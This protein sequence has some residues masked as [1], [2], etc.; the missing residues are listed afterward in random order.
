M[1]IQESRGSI[2][3]VWSDE[4]LLVIDKP[5]G[6]LTHSNSFDRTSPTVVM[7]LGSRLG[8]S[9]YNV[10]RLDRMTTGAMVVARTH[11][12]ARELSEQFRNRNVTKHYLAVVR[13][14]LDDA[15]S[16]T[17]PI[18]H[19]GHGD[20]L[21]AHTD[22]RT[23]A[24]GRVDEPIGRYGEG[25]FSLVELTLH[26]GRSHQARRH[27]H[28]VD[29]PVIGDNKH[30]DKVYNRWVWAHVQERHLFL[31]A[32]ELAIT[33]PVSGEPI[34]VRLGTPEIWLRLLDEVGI[35]LPPAYREDSISGPEPG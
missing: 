35:E 27:L 6:M 11:D 23:V 13:G 24:R 31:R 3:V 26:T 10:H 8:Q 22:Y 14:H 19:S 21:E 2:R 33:H 30:G 20:D 16:I 9:V 25:W 7:V 15:G 1:S 5:P 28:R 4:H 29:H 34:Q 12:A 18:A 17:S 32:R